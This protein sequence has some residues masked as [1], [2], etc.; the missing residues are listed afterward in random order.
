MPTLHGTVQRNCC[1]SFLHITFKGTG[2]L[3]ASEYWGNSAYILHD[4]MDSTGQSFSFVFS[5]SFF[6]FFYLLLVS[7]ALVIYY[8][9]YCSS[10]YLGKV[11]F[12]NGWHGGYFIFQYDAL[13]EFQVYETMTGRYHKERRSRDTW[14]VPLIGRY[15][16]QRRRGEKRKIFGFQVLVVAARLE[17]QSLSNMIDCNETIR[18]A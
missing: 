2:V 10:G 9:W 15:K 1:S 17:R 18:D 14:E 4:F 3:A 13:D 6:P 12:L 7:L 8:Y 11:D 16:I 5:S